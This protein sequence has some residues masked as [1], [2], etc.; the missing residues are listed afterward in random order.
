MSTLQAPT[1][2]QPRRYIRLREDL[3]LLANCLKNFTISPAIELSMKIQ[4]F[5][6]HSHTVRSTASFTDSRYTLFTTV[7]HDR[8][9]EGHGYEDVREKC[10]GKRKPPHGETGVRVAIE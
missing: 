8:C 3:L 9:K 1:S 6:F 4:K 5:R 7:R 2:T 10:T